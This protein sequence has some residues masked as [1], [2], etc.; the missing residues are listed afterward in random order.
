VI[1]AEQ[2]DLSKTLFR[3][4]TMGELNSKDVERLL[5]CFARLRA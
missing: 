1:Y 5:G 2:G 3:I 4:S